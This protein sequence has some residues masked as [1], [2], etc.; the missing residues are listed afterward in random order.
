MTSPQLPKLR[1]VDARPVSQRGRPAILVRDPLGLT[2]RYAVLPRKLAPLL[3]LCDGTR[4]S[5]GLRASLMIRF[6]IRVSTETI[7]QI[8]GTLDEALLLDNSRYDGALEQ[9]VADYRAAPFRMPV[10]A[11]HSYPADAGE[12]RRTLQ[13]YLDDVNDV[14]STPTSYRGLIS[15]HIDY[16][17]GGPVYAQTWK[18]AQEAV[19][20][21]DVA[22]VI[23]TDHNGGEGRVTLTRQHYATPYGT[24][25]TAH[26]IVDVLAEAVGP[27][28]AFA[29]ELH[30]RG[31]HSIELAAVWLHHIRG[32]EPCEVVPILCGSFGRYLRG[33]AHPAQDS[34]IAALIDALHKATSGRKVLF[35]AAADLAHIGPA[36]GG[37]PVDFTGRARV[38]VADDELIA[39]CC[40]GD[41]EGFFQAIR[42]NGGRYNVCGL[43]PIYL[44]LRALAPT[45]GEQ[46]AY[47]RCPADDKGTSLVSICGVVLD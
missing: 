28:L 33:E 26:G 36:F 43:A 18:H 40:A 39:R 37:A 25:P 45:S 47:K 30:H 16:G 44:T 2:E 14:G 32:G 29:D 41:A 38:Q 10:S 11:G 21:A 12:L 46:V 23:G 17:R 24:L 3:T 35:V 31:E 42:S 20:A 1:A 9:A 6:G 22:I 4:D 8:L 34:T 5:S 19:R 13:A 15:P 27:E 7:D